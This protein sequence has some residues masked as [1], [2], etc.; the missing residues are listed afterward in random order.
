MAW[1]VASPKI[2]LSASGAP[3]VAASNSEALQRA[4]IALSW[5]MGC[6]VDLD[7]PIFARASSMVMLRPPMAQSDTVILPC[8]YQLEKKESDRGYILTVVRVPVLSEQ[9]TETE[10]KVS[11]VLSDLQ[12]I[13]FFFIK[14]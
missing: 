8:K 7:K 1:S 5:E 10:P 2:F 6:P 3:A 13:L 11:T 12:R 4:E 14:F 9:T